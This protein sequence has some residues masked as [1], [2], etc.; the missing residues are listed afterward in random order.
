MRPR[1]CRSTPRARNSASIQ[2]MPT[3]SSSLSP[4]SLLDARNLLRDGK[5][6][7]VGKHQGADAEPDAPGGAGE[8]GERDERIHVTP[9]R[10]L[11]FLR[12]NG[13]MVH[14]PHRLQAGG[15]GGRGAFAHDGRCGLIAHVA[16]GDS[17]VHASIPPARSRAIIPVGFVGAPPSRRRRAGDAGAKGRRRGG[18]G[19][20]RRR[21]GAGTSG[22]R[23][24]P[25]GTGRPTRCGRC[26]NERADHPIQ[27]RVQE[28][29]LP[30]GSQTSLSKCSRGEHVA[31]IG[32]SGSGKTTILRIL[33]TLENIQ[34]G[35]VQVEGENLW[36]EER[37]GRLQP[38]S[39]AH[40]RRMRR[41]IGMVFQQFNL[42]PHLTV[43][44]N[45]GGA[46]EARA[47]DSRG[48]GEAARARAPGDGRA[49]RQGR[50]VSGAALGRPEAASGH[51]PGSEH[52]PE[53]HAFR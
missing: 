10:A 15:L 47:G 45:V 36:H 30:G 20:L 48:G 4:E 21:S 37:D 19:M 6:R 13:D 18:A 2:P 25:A 53:D 28:L 43:I 32:P 44:R 52:E 49:H 7:A 16:Y 40:L 14:D 42:F 8:P 22:R 5:R 35:T 31:L 26:G 3:P 51:R 39:E 17:D 11:G 24:N 9:L 27:R 41:S 50:S 46:A 1:R 38:A 23:S 34:G 29:R 33:M 12:G